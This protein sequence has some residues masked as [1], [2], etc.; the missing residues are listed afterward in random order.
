M[1][2]HATE[3]MTRYRESTQKG[4]VGSN[5]T[6]MVRRRPIRTLLI[7]AG[8]AMAAGMLRRRLRT[9]SQRYDQYGW[10]GGEGGTAYPGGTRDAKKRTLL[11]WLTDAHA[12]ERSVAQSL[13]NHAHDAKNHPVMRA[14]LERHLEET[15]HHAELVREC[16]ERLGGRVSMLKEGMSAVIGT[17]QGVATSPA[18]DELVK[19]IL[20]DS[21]A[22]RLEIASYQGIITAA[23]EI[24][25]HE[26]A[27]TCRQI[28]REEEAM[29]DWLE[30]QL[31]SAVRDQMAHA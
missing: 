29:S 9:R 24:G 19:N 6:G 21:A 25:D 8:L 4:G 31:P 23:D 22:E 13:R 26:T 20:A 7:G 16:I 3:P 17:V 18:K 28:L 5:L 2:D 27:Q 1:S 11:A 30:Q 10:A 14:R 12:M 15:R